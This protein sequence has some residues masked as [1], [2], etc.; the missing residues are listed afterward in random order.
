MHIEEEKFV[1]VSDDWYPNWD[2]DTVK[3]K[4]FLTYNETVPD[5]T[6]GGLVKIM[7]YGMDDDMVE[8]DFGSDNAKLEDLKRAYVFFKKCVYDNIPDVVSHEWF[9]ERGFYQW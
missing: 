3:V 4:V 6:F 7:A 2:G 5:G 9:E 8:L 1:K